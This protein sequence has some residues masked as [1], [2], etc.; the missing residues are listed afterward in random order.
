MQRRR[1]GGVRPV[2]AGIGVL[3][4]LA[5]TSGAEA[6]E[7]GGG[8]DQG[9]VGGVDYLVSVDEET[10]AIQVCLAAGGESSSDGDVGGVDGSADG[11]VCVTLT[12]P[13]PPEVPDSG[14][15]DPLSVVVQVGI[16][17]PEGLTTV[18]VGAFAD[19]NDPSICVVLSVSGP[20]VEPESVEICLPPSGDGLPG[21]P[22]LP[23]VPSLPETPSLP[24]APGLPELP[25]L[26][27]GPGDLPEL[28]DLLAPTDLLGELPILGGG[29]S[30]LDP[31]FSLLGGLGLPP[32]L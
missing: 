1:M 10:Q 26:P 14:I 3:S 12:P 19:V 6:V 21:L 30:P 17:T 11:S 2:I 22:G 4:A 16:P 24:E 27:G 20:G 18:D 25:G 31:V 28:G 29:G 5:F 23:G 7:V 8:S 15:N 32:A 9:V 13:T